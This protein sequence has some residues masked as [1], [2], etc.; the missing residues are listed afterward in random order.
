MRTLASAK[1]TKQTIA[2]MLDDL[3]PESLKV[4][5]QFV[6]FLRQQGSAIAEFRYPTV[7][8]PA[9]SLNTWAKLLREGYEGN[10]LVDT[11]DLYE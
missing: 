8:A 4:V 5:E 7:S 6:R 9:S 2:G 11:E 1:T 10:A 3:S